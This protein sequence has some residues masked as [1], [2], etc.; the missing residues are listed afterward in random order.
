MSTHSGSARDPFTSEP[1]KTSSTPGMGWVIIGFV[2]VCVAVAAVNM[3]GVSL[4][5]GS[6]VAS[7]SS[8]QG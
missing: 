1:S 2:L 7:A 4:T 5:G 6:H 8:V 3:G